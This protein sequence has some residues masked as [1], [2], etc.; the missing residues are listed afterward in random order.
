MPKIV[1]KSAPSPRDSHFLADWSAGATFGA[2]RRGGAFS[3]HSV[4]N[5]NYRNLLKRRG[6]LLCVVALGERVFSPIASI[7]PWIDT[8]PEPTTG[9]LN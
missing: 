8:G 5:R 1:L 9:G 3:T 2:L 6:S 4:H 7:R